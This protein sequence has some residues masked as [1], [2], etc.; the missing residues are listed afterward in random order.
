MILF[1]PW[2]GGVLFQ[3]LPAY[4]FDFSS[5]PSTMTENGPDR[6]EL[7]VGKSPEWSVI[8]LHGLGADGHDFEP[9]VAELGLPGLPGIRFVFPHAPYRAVTVNAGM[10]MRA[11][12]DIRAMD[13]AASPDVEGIEASAQ[14]LAALVDEEIAR[15]IAPERIVV[16]GFS[17]GG[18]VALHAALTRS[19]PVA[20]VIALSTYL[21]IPADVDAARAA[22]NVDKPIFLA[23]GTFDPVVPVALGEQAMRQLKGAGFDVEWHTYAMPHAVSPGEIGDIREWLLRLIGSEAA[24]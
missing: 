7:S 3:P 4:T 22:G 8:W 2:F 11:W 24:G 12:Y 21:P 23:H 18:A 9:V 6:V 16:A 14:Q 19:L 1:W 13:I 17:Q 15:G 20:G 10:R 5:E